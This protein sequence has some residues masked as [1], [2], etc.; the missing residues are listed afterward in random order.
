MKSYDGK[1]LDDDRRIFN[2][3]LSRARR[4]IEN[5]FGIIVGRFGLFKT[6]IDQQLDN[7][8]HAVMACCALHNFLHRTCPHSY[9]LIDCLNKD[10]TKTGTVTLGLR[11]N[12]TDMINLQRG[13]N[14]N[15]TEKAKV[16]REMLL[17]HFKNKGKFSCANIVINDLTNCTSL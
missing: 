3:R 7:I 12:P 16:A 17:T 14:R 10:D 8:D 2:Y 4:T 6:C 13:H 15:A 5:V 9:T 1:K 11:A